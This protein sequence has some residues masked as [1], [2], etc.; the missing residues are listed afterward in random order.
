MSAH[1]EERPRSGLALAGIYGLLGLSALIALFPL[2]WGIASSFSPNAEVFRYAYPFSWRSLVPLNFTL[3]AYAGLFDQ[4]FG[5][6]LGNTLILGL[7]TVVVGGGICAAA[8]FGFARFDFRFKKLLFAVVLITFMV[9]ADLT[10]IPRYLLVSNLGWVN[11][12]AALIVPGLA[13]SL[14]IFL[15]KQFFEEI[16]EEIIEAARLDGAS[17]FAVFTHIVL[18]L[19]KPMLVAA[20]LILFLSQ[21]EAFFWPLLVAPSPELQ[22]VQT[23]I[24]SIAVS[25]YKTV[26]NQLFAGSMLAALVP[27]VLTLPLQRYY[28][29]AVTGAVK[30]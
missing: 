1:G 7:T 5:R 3:E 8:G 23:A 28:V 16:P 6:A 20:A 12:W 22:L 19:S 27:I 18:P 4:G 26:W 9:P 30:G 29:Q 14:V 10:A 15:F 13:N 21:W 24:T 2:L 17:W 11:T 25:E